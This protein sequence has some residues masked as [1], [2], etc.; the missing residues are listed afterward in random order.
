MKIRIYV[1]NLLALVCFLGASSSALAD[2]HVTYLYNDA[3]G[4]PVAAADSSG[5]VLWRKAYSP[6][7]QE[8][9]VTIG[10]AASVVQDDRGFTGHIYDRESQLVYMGARHYNPRLGIFYST[11]PAEVTPGNPMSFNRYIYANQNPYRYV[12]PDGELPILIPLAILAYRAYSAYDT[13]MQAYDTVQMLRDPNTT[14]GDV[15]A[16][17]ASALASAVAGKVGGKLL[18]VAAPY[19]K[20]ALRGALQRF[21]P[22]CFV[23]GTIVATPSGAAAIEE[24]QVGDRVTTRGGGASVASGDFVKIAAT[25]FD[26]QYP[27]GPLDVTLLRTSGW[28][29]AAGADEPG[30]EFYLALAELGFSGVAKVSAV[31]IVQIPPGDGRL[32]TTTMTHLN[33]DVYEVRFVEDGSPLRGTGAHPLY[34]LDRDDWVQVRDLRVGERLQT[35]EGAVSVEAL[36]KVRGV[37]RVYNLEV[38]GDHEYLV[39]EAGVRAHNAC[40]IR[41]SLR[42]AGRHGL[43]G[44]RGKSGPFRFRAPRGHPAGEPLP[45]GKRGGYL[46][47]F[48]NEWTEGPYHGDPAKGFSREWDVQLSAEGAEH[49]AKYGADRGK[50]YINV[51]P[52]G[53]LSH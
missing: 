12:D 3:L 19:A 16:A 31:E 35:A 47:R 36:E 33:D 23:A 39:G 1:A 43:P 7:G 34:S 6:F 37:H 48:G 20:R 10:S 28:V 17:G 15:A 8:L 53:T 22:C 26:A 14:S 45:R 27:D 25:L 11:D 13:A 9:D 29:K 30:A 38:E 44:G 5:A 51:A 2:V 18:K 4:T 21:A 32:I 42:N 46:D 49:W 24:L 40:P 41:A 52:D 50:G